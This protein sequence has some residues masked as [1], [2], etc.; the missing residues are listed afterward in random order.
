MK[1]TA[2]DCQQI[3]NAKPKDGA[4]T[5]TWIGY[6]VNFCDERGN[7]FQ[8]STEL[9]CNGGEICRVTVDG[10]FLTVEQTSP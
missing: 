10:Q 7:L 5:G 4:Y 3:I 8:A 1:T 2:C 9:P 6:I